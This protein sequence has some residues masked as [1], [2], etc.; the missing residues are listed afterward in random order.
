MAQSDTHTLISIRLIIIIIAHSHCL[1]CCRLLS[2]VKECFQEGHQVRKSVILSHIC[3][4]PY[5]IY[6]C[7]H[8]HYRTHITFFFILCITLIYI[9]GVLNVIMKWMEVFHVLCVLTI[10]ICVD[11]CVRL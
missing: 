4:T 11:V 5:G 9:C 8:L 2:S 7:M 3:N 6:D 10:N 1:C